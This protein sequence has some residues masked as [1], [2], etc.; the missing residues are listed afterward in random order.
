[1]MQQMRLKL[2][3]GHLAH[4]S[5]ARRPRHSFIP[6]FIGLVVINGCGRDDMADQPKY[7]TL[8]GSNFFADRQAS[9]PIPAGTVARGH[10]ETDDHLFTGKIDG[11]DADAFPFPI[12]LDVLARGRE[13]YNIYCTV[14]HG[15]SGDGSG[16]IVQRG[17][18]RPPSFHIDRLRSAAPGHFFDVMTNGWGAMFSYNDRVNVHDRWAIAAY[19]RALQ[20]SQNAPVAQLSAEDRARLEPT[21]RPSTQPQTQETNR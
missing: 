9:R 19:I 16:M 5:W 14:C 8:G 17:F 10:L 1:M 12:T 11:K 20:L 21:T 3:R 2:W 7:K 15:A 4:A 18:T 6:L 13:R